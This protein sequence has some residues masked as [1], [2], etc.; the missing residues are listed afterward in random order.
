MARARSAEAALQPEIGS[1]ATAAPALRIEL[2]HEGTPIRVTLIK[3]AGIDTPYAHHARNDLPMRPRNPPPLCAPEVVAG[4][5]LHAAEHPVRELTVGGSGRMLEALDHWLPGIADR[6]MTR[7]LPGMRQSRIPLDDRGRAGLYAAAGE[8]CE[9]SGDE[10]RVFERSIY[11]AGVRH[12][13]ATLDVVVVG[14]GA[15]VFAGGLLRHRTRA[16]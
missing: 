4:A 6:V 9:R 10:T 1:A 16:R 3:P 15:L 13:L 2:M 5:I 7:L 12:P 8:A 11:I 14:T